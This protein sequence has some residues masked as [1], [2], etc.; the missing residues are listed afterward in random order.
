MCSLRDA[1]PGLFT[2]F[3]F[4]SGAGIS[5]DV[6]KNTITMGTES[7]V[8]L[9]EKVIDFYVLSIGTLH[10]HDGAISGQMVLGKR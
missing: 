1:S 2:T 5:F 6:D 3:W 8:F 10:Y 4:K 7:P 9:I